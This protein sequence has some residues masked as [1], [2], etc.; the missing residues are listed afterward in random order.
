MGG[1][2][3]MLGFAGG[4]SGTGFATPQQAQIISP[5]S[6]AQ[7]D[8]QYKQA[9]QA[10][11]QQQQFLQAVQAQGGLQNQTD[12]YNQLTNI[13]AGQ[14]PNPAQAQLAQATGANVANQAALM[15]GQRGSNAN[16]GLLA[17]QAAQQGAQTQQQAAGQAA[18][19]QA[20]QSLQALQNMGNLANQQAAQQ[21]AATN[22][23]TQ[24]TQGEQSNILN[25]I[26][27]TNQANVGMQGNINVQNAA[28]AGQKMTQQ[29]NLLGNMIP[30]AGQV[31]QMFADGGGVNPPEEFPVDLSRPV[32]RDDDQ[33]NKK[34]DDGGLLKAAIALNEGGQV[35]GPKSKVGQFHWNSNLGLTESSNSEHMT[36]AS[37]LGEGLGKMIGAGLKS[38]FGHSKSPSEKEYADYSASG[39]SP[40]Q[41]SQERAR[42]DMQNE[43]ALP[44][45]EQQPLQ[46]QYG[47]PNPEQQMAANNEMGM[48]AA[49]GGKVPALVSPGEHYLPPKDVKKVAKE[50]KSPLTVGERIPGKPKV[51]GDSYKNDT[52]HKTLEAGG[53]VIPNSIMQSEDPAKKAY[54]FV[55]AIQARH[56]KKLPKKK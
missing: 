27:N 15:A 42:A 13:A 21:A 2:S 20:N 52:V 5:A 41:M 9:Q 26:T 40:E 53:I 6:K 28:L 17:R 36:G 44:S 32:Y 25:A 37:A 38:I 35:K 7:A 23:Y 18:T 10:L 54:E 12:V 19:L 46:Q 34:K 51:K 30:A 31:M 11:Q 4:A 1:I 55:A 45:P 39:F 49:H 33:A 56:G 43:G 24:A 8:E 16:I 3:G 22:A 47:L 50:G 29:A 14:G 48:I